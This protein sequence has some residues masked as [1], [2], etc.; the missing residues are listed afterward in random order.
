MLRQLQGAL[1]DLK[2]LRRDKEAQASAPRCSRPGCDHPAKEQQV[3]TSCKIP[4]CSRHCRRLHWREGHGEACRSRVQVEEARLAAE[5]EQN[6]RA[7]AAAEAFKKAAAEAEQKRQASE[8]AARDRGVLLSIQEVQKDVEAA[9][10][11]VKD[12]ENLAEVKDLNG[13]YKQLLRATEQLTRDLLRLD[14]MEGVS[15]EVRPKRRETVQ[16][17]QSVLGK[18]DTAEKQLHR[19]LE[20]RQQSK[21]AEAIEQEMNEAFDEMQSEEEKQNQVDSQTP[22]RSTSPAKRAKLDSWVHRLAD[23]PLEISFESSQDASAY[24][25]QAYVPGLDRDQD[26]VVSL[27]NDRRTITIS[28][29]R[30]PSAEDLAK[31]RQ[32]LEQNRIPKEQEDVAVRRLGSG[33]FGSFKET[34]R[35][36]GDVDPRKIQATYEDSLIRVLLPKQ[37]SPPRYRQTQ[38]PYFSRSQPLWY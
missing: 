28:G 14:Q 11:R 32:F 16:E 23:L 30:L 37:P 24:E 2:G 31:L 21:A 19:L 9:E 27:D 13:A 25:L 26:L 15:E 38:N 8:Q 3:C 29:T 1:V 22:A 20:E 4:Y 6:A 34:Y 12:L 7:E 5:Q 33:R 10:H 35:L 36:P 18:L 17:V